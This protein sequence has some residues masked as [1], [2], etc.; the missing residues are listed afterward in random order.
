VA[1]GYIIWSKKSKLTPARMAQRAKAK[2]PEP[3]LPIRWNK[4]AQGLSAPV[5]D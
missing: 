2:M 4:L 1:S 3:L 5:R